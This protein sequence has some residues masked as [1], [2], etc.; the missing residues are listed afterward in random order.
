MAAEREDL[1]AGKPPGAGE[2]APGGFAGVLGRCAARPDKF[3][4][5]DAAELLGAGDELVWGAIAWLRCYQ[6]DSAFLGDLA[7]RVA[8][9]GQ[10]TPAQL[11]GVLNHL[12]A[13]G[14]RVRAASAAGSRPCQRPRGQ[15]HHRELPPAL[16]AELRDLLAGLEAGMSSRSAARRLRDLLAHGVP[17]R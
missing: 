12:R 15:E 8:A 13:D 11:R 17:D 14:R 10:L 4:D 7:V 9:D 2:S 6:G 1:L 16:A 3:T 5:A